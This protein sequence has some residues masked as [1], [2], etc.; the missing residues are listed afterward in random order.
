MPTHAEK[1][2]LPYSP[3]EMFDLVA[4]VE[5]YPQFLP[6]CVATRVTKSEG[7][8]IMAEMVIGYKMFRER[9]TS[10]VKLDS[11]GRIDVAY[12]EGPFKYLNNHWIFRPMEEGKCEIDFFVDFE[13]RSL[14]LQ[15]MI[16]LV[17]NEAVRIMVRAFAK[18]AEAVYGKR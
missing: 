1:R 13:F 4:D 6:W 14:L 10:R 5:K 18:R 9:F 8:E 11:P 17:F 2:L 15:R 12:F 3:E 7:D 16:G